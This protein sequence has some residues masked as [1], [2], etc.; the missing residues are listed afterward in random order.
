MEFACTTVASIVNPDVGD[1]ALSDLG[2]AF[3]RTTLA[4]EFAQRLRVRLSF[5]K[6][7][8]FLNLDEGMPYYQLILVKGP[9]AAQRWSPW[10]TRS[11]AR[12]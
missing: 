5:F 3:I 8:W 1:L 10:T 4:D 9:R 7:E 6:G 12:A 2:D 11:P